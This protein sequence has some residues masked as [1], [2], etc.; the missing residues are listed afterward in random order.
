MIKKSAALILV[1]LCAA[2]SAPS[3]TE[4]PQ[5]RDLAVGGGSGNPVTLPPM[6][7]FHAA[8]GTRNT[9]S[10]ADIA[11]DFMD[12]TF[13]MESGRSLARM[14]RFEGP[15]TLR[16]SG[17][18]PANAGTDLD[19]LLIRLRTEAGIA[20][21]R[22]PATTPASINI[23]TLP[24]ATMQRVVPNAACF[25]VP[26]LSSWHEYRRARRSAITDWTTLTT[27]KK[28]AIFIPS[29]VSPQEFRD[30]LHEEVAQSLGP[31]NDLYRL[32]DSVFNDDNFHSVLTG[33]DMLILRAYYAPEL[34][35][36]M[37]PSQV[38]AKL[39]SLL[40]R[41]NPAGRG[42]HATTASLTPKS[43]KKAIETALGRQSAL[44]QR[45]AAARNAI[46]IAETMGW[47]GPRRAFSHYAY[48]RLMMSE[49]PQVAMNA[50]V[51]A[52]KIYGAGGDA[53]IQEA[54]IATQMAAYFLST[55]DAD[56]ALN[57]VNGHM[58]MVTATHNASLLATMM[59]IK[60]EALDYLGRKSEA[61]RVRLDSL[62]WAQYGFGG[63]T[64]IT[65]RQ[66]EIASLVPSNLSPN[67]H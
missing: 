49:N 45:R 8:Q 19:K 64:I 46:A 31:L 57:L 29:D 7:T 55:G 67:A 40:D 18:T 10:N 33:F 15:I 42:G 28:V 5:R 47:T 23:E 14:S 32:P 43:W 39:P 62:G 52:R 59:M 12:L 48:G 9:R 63:K 4:V 54:H 30:C 53:R 61:H 51:T 34:H 6:K 56:Q 35:S 13:H 2:C 38:A 27:R 44:T 3:Q 22:V 26:R 36:G 66:R 60:A 17:R 65:T 41:Y 37:T 16:L 25:V 24:R 1:A 58:S 21:T 50:F 20:I 11:R